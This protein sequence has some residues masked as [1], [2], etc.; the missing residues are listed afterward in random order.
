M[1]ALQSSE[2]I[3]CFCATGI[4]KMEQ[5]ASTKNTPPPLNPF[6]KRFGPEFFKRIPDSPGVFWLLGSKRQLLF[7]GKSNNLKNRLQSYK[8]LNPSIITEKQ[9][10]L[11]HDIHD[12]H[13][14]QC[15]TDSSAKRLETELLKKY[16]PS[17][18]QTNSPSDNCSYIGY[19]WTDT[20]L[21]FAHSQV[22]NPNLHFFGAFKGKA[23]VTAAYNALMRVM[24]MGLHRDPQF[25]YP[26][27]LLKG[28]APKQFHFSLPKQ[29]LQS[30][31][32]SWQLLLHNFFLGH[33]DMILHK[34]GKSIESVMGKNDSFH[35]NWL[36]RD[37]DCLKKFY[38]QGP[39]KNLRIRQLFAFDSPLVEAEW[40]DDLILQSKKNK[41]DKNK[42]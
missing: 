1:P 16:S 32:E 17:Y 37:L 36:K 4:G 9:Q 7:V 14:T 30:E 28:S 13:W 15:D 3:S 23:P 31:Q 6:Q 8:R 10:H 33:S 11:L 40:L 38:E 2:I 5:E 19:A 27:P 12:I 35:Q 22:V 26:L 41:T 29:L 39:I 25:S 21:Y 24:W 42:A 18:N 34:L 20:A